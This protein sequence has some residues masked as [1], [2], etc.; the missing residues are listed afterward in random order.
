MQDICYVTPAKKPKLLHSYTARLALLYAAIFS[1]STLII[2]YFFY[3]FT[4]SYM[5]EQM[6]N[7]I[8][9]EIQ[10]LAERYNQ[11]GLEGLSKLISERVQRQNA[12]EKS[13]YLLTNYTL[14]PIVGNL[15]RWPKEAIQ[16]GEWLEFELEKSNAGVKHLARARIFRL[17]GRY[18]LLV[19]RDI[20]QLIQVKKRIIQALIWGL[21]IMVLLAVIGGLLLSR[22]T[23]RKIEL[24]NETAHSIM[25][26][27]LSQRIK[28]SK[29]NDDFDQ[30]SRN[31]NNM[32]DRIQTL[33]EDIRRVSDNIAHDLK[34]PLARLKQ[35]LEEA[36]KANDA[37][38]V[39]NENLEQSIREAD[40]LLSTFNALLRIARI[41][42]GQAKSN[43]NPIDFHNLLSDIV[44]FYEPLA[45]D[46]NQVI[47]CTLNQHVESYGDRDMLFQV[48]ANLLENSIK[49]TPKSGVIEVSLAEKEDK[50]IIIIADNG[51]G[52]PKDER[53]KVF[54]RFYRLDQSRT[55]S[56]NGL[57]LSLVLAVIKMHQGKIDLQDNHPGLKNIITIPKLS[58]EH[59]Q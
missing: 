36:V 31:L 58:S 48:L 50:I 47:K 37:G 16:K 15:D 27:D 11:E 45:E 59:L 12:T 42:V 49:Y 18:G 24:I 41:E 20:Y 57:G 28:L 51:P 17:P 38:P 53:E 9:A 10:G 39:T 40:L 29:R 14:D 35:K 46:K 54:Q 13:I 5:T 23:V 1:G 44:E 2:F 56:G 43:F 25:S 6:D 21:A 3:L 26:G 52:I 19:G 8:Q 34:T 32:L 4:A 55:T 30:L 7:T 33:M 22:R